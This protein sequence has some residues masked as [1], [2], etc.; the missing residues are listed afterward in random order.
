[1]DEFD[2]SHGKVVSLAG[3]R[4][5]MAP[6]AIAEVRAYW[7]GLRGG[8]AAPCRSEVDPRGIERSLEHAFVLERIAPQVAR[9][10]LAGMHLNDLM[11]ME[12]RGMPFTTLFTP[13]AR[14]EIGILLASVFAGPCT[15]ELMLAGESG[16]G[17]PAL[18]GRMVLLPLK[19]DLGDVSRILGCLAT[20]GAIGRAPRRFDLRESLVRPVAAT[21]PDRDAGSAA[22]PPPP[23]AGFAEPATPFAAAPARLERGR[24]HLRLVVSDE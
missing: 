2:G 6:A 8:R 23:A 21:A 20:E 9:F 3:N 5:A 7:E 17:K 4:G 12:V 10:R 14:R 1:M 24:A 15:A 13:A 16:F 18:A 19:S 22:A 11:G